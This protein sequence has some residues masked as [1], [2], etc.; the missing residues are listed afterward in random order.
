MAISGHRSSVTEYLMYLIQSLAS[1]L[2]RHTGR[3]HYRLELFITDINV[4]EMRWQ[5]VPDPGCHDMETAKTITHSP[6]TW[7][8][9][10][11]IIGVSRAKPGAKGNGDD[12]YTDVT[13]I[14]W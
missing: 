11:F 2:Q 10:N 7:H 1:G 13:E 12:R 6:S 8:N 4:V 9:H 3:H 5:R 14:R